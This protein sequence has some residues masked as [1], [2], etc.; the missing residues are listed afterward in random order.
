MLSGIFTYKLYTVHHFFKVS[1]GKEY[2]FSIVVN[3]QYLGILE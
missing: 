3:S 2:L 1:F